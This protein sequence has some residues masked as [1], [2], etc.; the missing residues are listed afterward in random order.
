MRIYEKPFNGEQ[1][2]KSMYILIVVYDN[3][4][5]ILKVI[6]NS[7]CVSL[8]QYANMNNRISFLFCMVFC[9]YMSQEIL[10]S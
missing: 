8:W 4:T 3:A 6:K 9:V 5:E 2:E 7:A 10:R 1:L